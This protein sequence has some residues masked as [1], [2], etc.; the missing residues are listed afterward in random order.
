LPYIDL[1][2]ELLADKISP[3]TDPT[4]TINPTWK[5][6]SEGLTSD[7]LTAAPQYF[8]QGAYVALFDASYP[9]TLPYSTGLDELR[10]YLQQWTLPLWQLRQA[11]LP[12]GGGSVAQQAA[13]A[14]ERLGMNVQAEDLVTIP[15]FVSASVAWNT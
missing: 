10:T 3:A 7:Q 2:N 14:A 12:V 9:Q 6:T 4:S 13:V 1:V 5:Q 15:N 8:N 11:L